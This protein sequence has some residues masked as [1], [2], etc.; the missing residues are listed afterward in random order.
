MKSIT[1]L[2]LILV[3]S[4]VVHAQKVQVG[5]DPGV[6]IS[7]FK[8]YAWDGKNV[9]AN[10]LV[11]QAIRAAVDREM[12]KKGLRKVETDPELKV[13]AVA[14]T[15]TDLTM[16]YPSWVPNMNSISTGIV[17]GT[18]AWPVTRGM[19]VIDLIESKTTNSVWRG[20]ATDTLK[21]G[22]SG[23]VVKDAKSVQKTIDK[24]VEK[25]FKQYPKPS[26]N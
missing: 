6:D 14:A 3:G 22:P 4:A 2:L 16:N 21:Q 9:A 19:L 26:Q 18:T 25:M 13:V 11:G 12:A 15:D 20:S 23:N 7:K 24:A 8:T 10:P 1:L 17:V 5:A